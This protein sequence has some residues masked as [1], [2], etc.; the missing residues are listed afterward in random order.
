MSLIHLVARMGWAHAK[1]LKETPYT[2]NQT[3]LIFPICRISLGHAKK[4]IKYNI[5]YE[6]DPQGGCVCLS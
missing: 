2:S 6:L 1:G 5:I 4:I 3:A